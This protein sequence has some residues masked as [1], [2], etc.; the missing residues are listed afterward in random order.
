MRYKTVF[1]FTGIDF[2]QEMTTRVRG[3]NMA[4]RKEEDFLDDIAAAEAGTF[5]GHDYL[6]E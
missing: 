5:V 3:K 4:E 1:Y 2:G 6:N